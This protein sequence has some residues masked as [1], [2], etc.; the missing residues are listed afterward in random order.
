MQ[1]AR[2]AIYL[3][4]KGIKS[5]AV[6]DILGPLSYVP[7]LVNHCRINQYK[8]LLIVTLEHIRGAIN[9]PVQPLRPVCG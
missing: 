6:E 7:T 2:D 5:T 3:Q 1:I 4:G 9:R 8:S